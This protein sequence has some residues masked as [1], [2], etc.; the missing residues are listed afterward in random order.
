MTIMRIDVDGK[1]Y[2]VIHFKFAINNPQAKITKRNDVYLADFD[3]FVYALGF[4]ARDGTPESIA[5]KIEKRIK[6]K[7]K[8]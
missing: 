1:Q 2:Q 6:P 3:G 7:E 5:D 8:I 4:T